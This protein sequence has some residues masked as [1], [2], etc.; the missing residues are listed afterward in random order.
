MIDIVL[1]LDVFACRRL[2]QKSNEEANADG[3]RSWQKRLIVSNDLIATNSYM[4]FSA[5]ISSKLRRNSIAKKIRHAKKL[6]TVRLTST[7]HPVPGNQ[8]FCLAPSETIVELV[9]K[10]RSLTWDSLKVNTS[11]VMHGRSLVHFT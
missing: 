5:V 9:K 2:E 11:G 10:I 6:H 3:K 1:Y 7:A 8:E 4:F